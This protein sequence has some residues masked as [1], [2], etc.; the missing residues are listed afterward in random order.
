MACVN[1]S[2]TNRYKDSPAG[3]QSKPSAGDFSPMGDYS[4]LCS[5]V[6]GCSTLREMLEDQPAPFVPLLASHIFA[7]LLI[8]NLTSES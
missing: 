4:R 1:S 6:P 5:R 8:D 7:A 3:T 2:W